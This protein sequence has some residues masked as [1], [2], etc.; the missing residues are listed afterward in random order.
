MKGGWSTTLTLNRRRRD[1]SIA[2]FAKDAVI[3][4]SISV[5]GSLVQLN[6]SGGAGSGLAIDSSG[7]VL[8]GKTVSGLSNAGVEIEGTGEFLVT[9]NGTW[10]LLIESQQMET[11]WPLLNVV[12]QLAPS[13]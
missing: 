12:P 9:R 13:P 1:G 7:N 8:V 6:G 5:T 3:V 11:Q 10:L 4:G 2:Q